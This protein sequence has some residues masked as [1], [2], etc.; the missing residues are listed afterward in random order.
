MA[1]AQTFAGVSTQIILAQAWGLSLIPY[2][3]DQQSYID[4]S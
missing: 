2:G 1:Q 3:D 4:N